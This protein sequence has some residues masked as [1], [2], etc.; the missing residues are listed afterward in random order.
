MYAIEFNTRIKDG[1]IEIPQQYL[2][3]LNPMV[4][5]IILAQERNTEADM[6]TKLLASPLKIENFTPLPREEIYD[7][8]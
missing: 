8:H 5:V 4:K 3:K 2:S 1:L 6:I 7:R